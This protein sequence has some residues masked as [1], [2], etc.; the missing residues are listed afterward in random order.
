MGRHCRRICCQSCVWSDRCCRQTIC[1]CVIGQ[2]T[3]T[4]CRSSNSGAQ[5]LQNWISLQNLFKNWSKKDMKILRIQYLKYSTRSLL[6]KSRSA[7]VFFSWK[8]RSVAEFS[9]IFK[10][11]HELCGMILYNLAINHYFRILFVVIINS[12]F[13]LTFRYWLQN[14]SKN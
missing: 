7:P 3:I 13:P 5:V 10:I 8:S 4:W 14:L 1:E 12:S 11:P 9:E 6:L 2:S